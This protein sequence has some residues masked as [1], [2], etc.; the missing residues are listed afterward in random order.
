M[1]ELKEGECRNPVVLSL[2]SEYAQVLLDRLL[3]TLCLS[4][5]LRVEGGVV[6]WLDARLSQH[7]L[8]PGKCEGGA[9]VRHNGVG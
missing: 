4:I 1:R 6:F 5:R 2:V 8:P 9:T 7:L 3:Q